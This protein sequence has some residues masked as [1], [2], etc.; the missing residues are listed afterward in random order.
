VAEA[1][2]FTP[3][4]QVMT[5]TSAGIARIISPVLC[6][7]VLVPL[8]VTAQDSP[9]TGYNA[10]P[11]HA[12]KA[13]SAYQL[14]LKKYAGV[15]HVLVLPGLTAN[16]KEQRVDVFAEATGIETGMIVEFL[17]IDA[18]SSKGYEAL[19]W[20]H[21]RPS[22][23]H[24]ALEFI[25]M[26]PGKPFHPGRL[27]FWAKG[28][29]VLPGI[30]ATGNNDR[31]PLE[32]LIVDQT[33]NRSLPV[34]GFVFAGSMM[35]HKSEI[36]DEKA[37]AADVMDPRSVASIY[38]D[39]TAVLD[40]PRRAL[41]NHVYGRQRV[42]PTYQ[43]K[44]NERLT[45]TL[46]PEYKSGRK[47]V[48]DISLSVTPA[49]KGKTNL[50][51]EFTLTD[52]SGR[53]ILKRQTLAEVLVVFGAMKRDG[54][55]PFV[56]VH[57]SAE[58]KLGVVRH[59][60]RVLQ[61]I[62]TERGIRVE[63]PARQQLYYEAFLPDAQL[64][65]RDKRI[66]DPWEVHL[67]RN[68]NDQIVARVIRHKSQFVDGRREASVIS[69]D[70]LFALDLRRHLD[71]EASLRKSAG[72]RPGPRVLIVFGKSDMDYRELV[73]FLTPAMA[74]HNVIHVFL[75]AKAETRK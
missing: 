63:P 56:S 27:R 15:K 45:V 44:K 6:V 9:P 8:T 70:T 36:P 11:V 28:E 26:Q 38:N 74:T 72:Q 66:T 2:P 21:A 33:V 75:D 14:N 55:D 58:L 16:R 35:V 19:I 71:A 57:F 25:G 54:R 68:G 24:R 18:A 50:S 49:A 23:I 3:L 17:L 64:L 13:A 29:R 48:A 34:T 5:D 61:A 51:V 52:A 39:T 4:D 40:V 46:E 60:C 41:Q 30:G 32:S 67:R 43:F 47:R 73:N 22:D 37:Y 7:C 12:A 62:D 1:W 42:S 53:S 20:S 69:Q 59:V 65:D 31:I 10:R